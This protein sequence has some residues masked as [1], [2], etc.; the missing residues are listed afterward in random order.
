MTDN[1]LAESIY[2]TANTL[3][4]SIK[5]RDGNGNEYWRARELAE[6]LGYSDFRN[7]E[8]VI[9]KAK[10]SIR[11]SGDSVENHFGEATKMVEVGS[12]TMRE[13]RD[14]KLSRYAC[15]IISQNGD[16]TKNEIALAQA[17][18]AQQARRQE[19]SVIHTRE[20]ERLEARQK[21]TLS[22]KDLSSAVMRRGVNARGLA[23]IKSQGDKR[24][25][26]GKSTQDMKVKYKI[27]NKPL[28][29]HLPTISL[30]AKQLVNE[31][32]TLNTDAKDLQGV[33][34]IGV[35]HLKN[36]DEIRKSLL[37]RRIKLEDLP[38]EEDIKKV[39]RRIKG[40]DK[41]VE[42]SE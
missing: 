37:A 34:H 17:Y 36:N 21:L 22:D 41:R 31:M 18:F 39:E 38:S 5:R 1:E 32:T 3:F 13:I 9:E 7:F 26:G 42:I 11:N 29:D 12:N 8:N 33:G 27:K 30:T 19:L 4:D 25:F 24:L 35:E 14:V 10:V 2:T 20:V 6:A 28:A 16:P 15:Y 40:R 23:T